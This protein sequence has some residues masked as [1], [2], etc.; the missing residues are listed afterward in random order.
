MP[1]KSRSESSSGTDKPLYNDNP[2]F[3]RGHLESLY[4][5]LPETQA[6]HLNLAGGYF[7][8]SNRKTIVMS[9]EHSA[10]IKDGSLVTPTDF[11]ATF[12]K[13]IDPKRWK[14][15][16]TPLPSADEGRFSIQPEA[17][18]TGLNEMLADIVGS[19]EDTESGK[20]AKR[21]AGNCPITLLNQL[22]DEADNITNTMVGKIDDL[23]SKM[24]D[25]GTV[26]RHPHRLLTIP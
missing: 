8:V 3:L 5:W 10:A 14:I 12:T 22:K 23:M 20:D 24:M 18:R 4:E 15:T 1:D 25:D 2:L 6:N 9:A 13:P 19:F 7:M 17:I 16:S 21:E 26:K 11:R